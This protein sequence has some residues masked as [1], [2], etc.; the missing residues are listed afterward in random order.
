M[1]ALANLQACRQSLMHTRTCQQGRL[2]LSGSTRCVAAML[3]K[4]LLH[5][6][7]VVTGTVTQHGGPFAVE[8]NQLPG[9]GLSLCRIGV[10]QAGRAAPLQHSG[11][12]PADIE[13]ILHG[14]IHALSGFGAVG[15]AG[16]TRNEDVRQTVCYFLGLKVVESIA[17]AL[18]NFIH[19]PPGHFF[20]VQRV[21]VKNTLCCGNQL[22]KGDVAPGHALVF[23]K[24]VHLYI[25]PGHITAF[26]RND[27]QTAFTGRL[28]QRLETEIRKVG[29]DQ[30]VHH[31]PGMVGRL[32]LQMQTHGLAHATARTVAT[33]NVAGPNGFHFALVAIILSLELGCNRVGVGLIS[34]AH[35]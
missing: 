20:H 2:V 29:V 17:Q 23:S 31:A 16:V 26:A 32:A 24:F 22:F 4:V 8:V 19:R 1:K 15:V 12:L 9:D 35:K 11:Q 3:H 21:G 13:S 10:K 5:R 7:S 28:D 27:Q 14:D 25:N 6:S 30:Y 18:T 33:N 34:I